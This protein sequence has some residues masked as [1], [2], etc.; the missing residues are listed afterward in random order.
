MNEPTFQGID[1]TYKA[2]ADNKDI[3]NLLVKLVPTAK[4][5]T[6]EFA[7]QFKGRTEVE[8]CKKI[9][10]YLCKLNY[11]ADGGEQVIKLPSAL[12]ATK[13]PS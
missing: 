3:R 9:F 11:V 13:T 1:V 10:E 6:V 4:A 8:T 2:G 12:I 5:Q 7:K